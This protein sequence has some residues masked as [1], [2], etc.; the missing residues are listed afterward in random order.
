MDKIVKGYPNWDVPLNKNIEEYNTTMGNAELL[1]EDK[2]IKGAINEI[3]TKNDETIGKIKD[4]TQINTA[5]ISNLKT[6]VAQNSS[7]LKESTKEIDNLK[8][9]QLEYE[10]GNW[11]P[12]V[13]TTQGNFIATNTGKYIKIGNLVTCFA[14]C[15]ITDL[16]NLKENRNI[17]ISGF[18]FPVK[19]QSSGVLNM[20]NTTDNKGGYT[21]NISTAGNGWVNDI[22]ASGINENSF[23][24]DNFI[25]TYKC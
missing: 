21:C 3:K 13:G 20:A 12:I 14:T 17:K 4:D 16:N 24:I 23:T 15:K 5:D 6:S 2:T 11:T 8:S 19:V 9:N 18:P 1:T 22:L 10:E 25:I 7:Q